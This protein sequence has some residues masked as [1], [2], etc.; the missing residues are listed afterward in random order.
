V[1][2]TELVL[3]ILNAAVAVPFFHLLDKLKVS[4]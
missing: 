1:P 2:Q 4:E 3:A